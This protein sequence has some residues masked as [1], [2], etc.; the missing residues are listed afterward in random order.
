VD[1]A[2][3]LLRPL[4]LALAVAAGG[5]VPA[6]SRPAG[7]VK[8]KVAA[9]RALSDAELRR[10]LRAEVSG[11]A[12]FIDMSAGL[13][14][15]QD[16]TG[17]L[18]VDITGV[19]EGV[20]G[21]NPGKLIVV[22]GRLGLDLSQH[23]PVL[24]N[25]K[26]TWIEDRT[27]PPPEQVALASLPP[28]RCDGRW[29]E[30]SGTVRS[31]DPA[32]PRL[33]TLDDADHRVEVHLS[34]AP[35]AMDLSPLSGE[36]VTVRGVC[37]PVSA[38]EPRS[39]DLRLYVREYEDIRL[40]SAQ[41]DMLARRARAL[42]VLT[43]IPAVRGLSSSEASHYL[44]V[45][46]QAVV[47]YY[48]PKWHMS[49]VNDGTTGIYTHAAVVPQPI[50][51]G[52]RVDVEGWSGPGL[53]AP[54]ITHATV[55]RIG[56]AALPKP[57]HVTIDDLLTGRYDSQWI[58]IDGTVR[59][60][61]RTDAGQLLLTLMAAQTR[62]AVMIP[63]YTSRAIPSDL[64]DSQVRIRSASGSLFNTRR[65][66][67]GIR[68][69]AASID[70]IQVLRPRA[71][72][73][74]DYRVRTIDALM[75][76]SPGEDASERQV[77]RGV[78]T[79]VNGGSA[80]LSDG[81]GG[82]EVRDVNDVRAGDDLLVAGFAAPGPYSP[83]MEDALIRRLGRAPM[84]EPVRI[85]ADEAMTGDFDGRLVRLRARLLDEVRS[86]KGPVLTLQDGQHVFTAGMEASQDWFAQLP[87]NGSILDVAGILAVEERQDTTPTVTPRSIHVLMRAP[88]DVR[89]VKRAPW[90]TITHTLT[91][92][93]I[94][95]LAVGATGGWAFMLRRQ[96]RRQTRT[97]REAKEA[98]EAA[99]RAKD[100][101][102]ANVSH[103]I[104]TPMNG[105][106]G[107]TDLALGTTLT[108]E[109]HEYL[110]L[111]K[112]SADSLLRLIDELLDL[113]KVES[114]RVDPEQTP[115]DI[116]AEVHEALEPLRLRAT[117]KSLTFEWRID[118]DVPR[119]LEGD[120]VRVRQ[121]LLNLAANAI[122]FTERGGVTV[123][124]A[125]ASANQEAAD[126]EFV[127]ADTGIGIPAE[128]RQA[129]F[130][131]FTQADGSTTRRYGGTGLGL[132]IAARLVELMGGRIS[133]ES[134]VGKGTTFHVV[135]PFKIVA[136]EGLLPRAAVAAAAAGLPSHPLRI[137]IAED[138]PVSEHLI[139]RMLEK[140]GHYV[141]VART[142]KHAVD[143]T[144]RQRF[145]VVLMDVQMP[146]MDGFNATRLIRAR[147]GWD[148]PI[149]AVTAR[150]NDKDAI[151]CRQAGMDGYV[152]K[153]L[154]LEELTAAIGR[155]V[156]QRQ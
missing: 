136:S 87:P 36:R 40:T 5:F 58:E 19:G 90:W 44:P 33:L 120:A 125:V 12:T 10:D 95:T 150:A 89:T 118:T 15:L 88:S 49:F 37:L 82:V 143:L 81:T 8:M 86:E 134:E 25:P 151:A 141:E 63:D 129:V 148:L 79:L 102:L 73:P 20:Y 142:G 60:A 45:R 28:G 50:A 110:R 139:R 51:A 153:P 32:T 137:L 47:T 6:C 2:R 78:V 39:A 65:Q 41:Q 132:T 122:K 17:A 13:L 46:L 127:V 53:F 57:V 119:T 69:Y 156:E 103:E 9:V 98:A 105:I 24:G 66:L 67:T 85:T 145:D 42:P 31:T 149:I 116:R 114:G 135:L 130:E 155:A 23:A 111:A 109:Q 56:R 97:L 62:F 106:L 108:P 152:T 64:L 27:V 22:R 91:A 84:P 121:I 54:E 52:D 131:A 75:R 74:F 55:R 117:A 30:I 26:I 43:S 115:F 70:Q 59:A 76:F 11:I 21:L 94:L 77:I 72:N 92:L 138:N 104:R 123:S 1:R 83:V 93:A 100:D 3:L 126:L 154:R 14:V 71:R 16:D 112:S 61:S 18:K 144:R 68:Q 101:F 4:I 124:V 133:L 29:I 113:S 107:L 7:V 128:K 99:N 96:V 140:L 38:R 147:D 34:A 146:E 48:D 80:F 35:P